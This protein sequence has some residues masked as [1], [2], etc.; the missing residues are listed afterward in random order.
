MNT[1]YKKVRKEHGFTLIE[2]LVVIGI[3]A[4]LSAVVLIAINPGR[5][6]K[7]ARDSQRTANVTAI[8][9][10]V[11]QNITENKGIFSCGGAPFDIPSGSTVIKK[12]SGG[13]DIGACLV[14]IYISTLPYDPSGNAF[15]DNLQSYDTGYSIAKDT[16][17]RITISAQSEVNP[18]SSISI[19]R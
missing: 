10:A 11:G 13:L 12:A 18:Q 2:V 4:I 1:N 17:G 7:I 19:S 3:V 6:F 14:P 8:L 5:Q 16:E 9:D 15:Y